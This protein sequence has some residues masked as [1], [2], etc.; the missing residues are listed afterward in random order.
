[1]K[2]LL[3]SLWVVSM[4]SACG[5]L[6]HPNGGNVIN[7]PLTQE[8]KRAKVAYFPNPPPV[9]ICET[10][11]NPYACNDIFIGV[12]IS[13]GGSRAANFGLGAINQLNELGLY[14]EVTAISAVSG[15]A[16]AA[17]AI[18]R[19]NVSNES[20]FNNLA[21][22]LKQDFLS[23]WL[24]K[25]SNP[26]RLFRTVT[27]T[28]NATASLADVFD[29]TIF[30]GATYD[31]LGEM[32]KGYPYLYLNS[33][34]VHTTPALMD[35]TTRGVNQPVGSLQGFTFTDYAFRKIGSS[36]GK[37]RL[38]DAVAASGAYP[39]A[40]ES[41]T[42]KNY[43][44]IE[45]LS[46]TQYLHLTDG[47]IADNLGVDALVRAYS[48]SLFSNSSIP[49]LLI[50]V[51]AHVNDRG[52]EKGFLSDLRT[53]PIDYAVSPSMLLAFD[54]LLDR[55]REEQLNVLGLSLHKDHPVRFQEH[56]AFELGNAS[57]YPSANGAMQI[58]SKDSESPALVDG[59]HKI[60]KAYCA[61]WHV[62]LDR[63]LELSSDGGLHQREVFGPWYQD[64]NVYKTQKDKDLARLD[65]FVNAVE[66]NYK[67]SVNGSNC[68][69]STIQSSLFEAAREL[70]TEDDQS[71]ILLKKWLSSHGRSD[72]SVAIEK[73]ILKARDYENK[74]IYPEYTVK[75]RNLSHPYGKWIECTSASS[76]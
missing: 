52:D 15:G 47:G 5:A 55:K 49:C 16:L 76:N 42:L 43:A 7:E 61:V 23:K 51:D 4:L 33:S 69:K 3:E 35:V 75:E 53:N 9:K 67:L 74:F 54:G 64:E 60:E 68:G 45:K 73:R 37:L 10:T 58:R 50:L 24:V 19:H 21:N 48:E 6:P 1:M 27:T 41:V 36:L 13:G 22:L 30:H 44:F 72:L 32:S 65:Y 26:Y 57:F 63:L 56:V 31:S 71:I 29:D 14:D 39:G 70:L 40:F 2:K 18:R 59:V 66:T 8:T 46:G 11:N 28:E 12:A 34:L 62:G 17:A 38:A 25:S 20:A